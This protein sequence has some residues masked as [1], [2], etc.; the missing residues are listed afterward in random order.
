MG[1]HYIS[2]DGMISQE[3]VPDIN[4]FSFRMLASIVS[5]LDGT[6]IITYERDSIYSVTIVLESLSDLKKLCITSSNYDIL[7]FC[8]G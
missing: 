4:V 6:L 8:R 2:L 1:N 7:C 3:V 5:N